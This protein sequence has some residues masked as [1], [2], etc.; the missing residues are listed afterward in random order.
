MIARPSSCRH[1]KRWNIP[2]RIAPREAVSARV[3]RL[4]IAR[5]YSIY[6]LATAA[7]VFAPTI[8][9]LEAGEAAEKRVFSALATALGVPL[10]QLVCGAHN[11]M[12]RACVPASSVFLR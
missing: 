7:G 6:E 10:C 2:R 12:E 1:S 5:G 3:F 8:E 9:R 11:C 4:R